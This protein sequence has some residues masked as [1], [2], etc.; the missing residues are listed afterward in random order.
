ML[1][2]ANPCCAWDVREHRDIMIIWSVHVESQNFLK[3]NVS[4]GN[5]CNVLADPFQVVCQLTPPPRINTVRGNSCNVLTDPFQVVCQ[6][7]PPGSTLSDVILAMSSQILSKLCVNQP[8]RI[9]I[10]RGNPCNVLADPFQV[11]CW[12]TSPGSTLSEV[13]LALSLWILSKLCVDWSPWINIVR[14]NPYNI[15]TDPFQVCV[16]QPPPGSTLSEVILPMSLQILSKLCVDW[17]PRINIVRGNPCSVLTDP[18]QVV[19]Q[20][21]PWINIVRGNPCNVLM[22]PF[23]VVC[24]LTPPRIN[25]VRGNP[26][27]VLADPFQ[28]MCWLTSPGSTLSE[29]ILALS[30]WILSKLCVDWSPWINI[31][32]GNPYNIPTDPFQVCVNQPPQDQHCQR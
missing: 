28:V 21:T 17:P 12:L 32:R 22:D 31:V 23:Q 27:N 8:P 11:V 4:W 6:S 26:C 19:C 13:I 20:L 9:N 3:H 25:I 24:Q 30:L 29:V 15:P 7:T 10:V 16:N 18:F 5:P 2:V 14:G 1:L